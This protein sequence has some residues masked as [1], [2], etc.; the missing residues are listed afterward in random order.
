MAD[1]PVHK[2]IDLDP[3]DMSLTMFFPQGSMAA[4]ADERALFDSTHV[5]YERGMVRLAIQSH[6]VSIGGAN[7]LVDACIGE[8]KARPDRPHWNQRENTGFLEKLAAAGFKAEDID[9]VFCTHL[10]ADHVGW[11]TRLENG[12]W[13]PT[14]PKARYLVGATELAHWRD[15]AATQPDVNHGSYR[16]SVAPVLEA[17]LYTTVEPGDRFVDGVGIV[18]LAGHSAGQIGLELHRA[19][20][21]DLLLCG[22]ALHS[23]VQ[24]SH[25]EW[26]TFVCDDPIQSATTRKNLIERVAGG[27]VLL[28]PAHLRKAPALGVRR[29]G[30]RHAPFFCDCEGAPV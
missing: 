27:D 23:P 28:M 16:D 4:I 8:H 21:P 15:Q 12:R 1:A 2:I 5:D 10:H 11:N 19:A 17:G 29:V 22:D 25:P 6:V 24:V 3:V 26:S 7:V 20:G 14:F 13:V 18:S 30:G 9:F